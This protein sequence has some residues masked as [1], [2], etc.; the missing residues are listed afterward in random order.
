M[1]DEIIS[2]EKRNSSINKKEFKFKILSKNNYLRKYFT[3]KSVD[4]GKRFKEF[5]IENKDLKKSKSYVKKNMFNQQ[6][7]NEDGK[8]I[9]NYILDKQNIVNK[10]VHN[11]FILKTELKIKKGI[12]NIL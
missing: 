2:L 6:S 11:N 7:K 8:D 12:S 9:S 3:S 10:K 5:K 4:I 1:N